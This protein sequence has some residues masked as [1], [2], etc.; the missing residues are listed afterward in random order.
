V[1]KFKARYYINAHCGAEGE[2]EQEYYEQ[3]ITGPEN[4]TIED[5]AREIKQATHIYINKT[6]PGGKKCLI[7]LNRTH[8]TH[9]VIEEL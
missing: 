8:I 9:F 6:L 4:S 7:V 1:K 2:I 5:A 3:D